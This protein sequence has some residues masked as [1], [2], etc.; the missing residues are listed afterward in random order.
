ML[1]IST[2]EKIGRN[3]MFEYQGRVSGG[4]MS[5]KGRCLNISV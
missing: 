1:S 2:Q 5:V 3:I 4:V